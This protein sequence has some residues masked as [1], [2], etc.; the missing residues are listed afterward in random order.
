MYGR[1]EAP[2]E[3]P[4]QLAVVAKGGL[5]AAATTMRAF[6]D[7]LLLMRNAWAVLASL[8]SETILATCGFCLHVRDF[9]V[10]LVPLGS[11]EEDRLLGVAREKLAGTE[12]EGKSDDFWL[13]ACCVSS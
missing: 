8:S 6:P 11:E 13:R 1:T 7:D 9:Y 4:A 2:D 3:L 10:P 12:H 5:P